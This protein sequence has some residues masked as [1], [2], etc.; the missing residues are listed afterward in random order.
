M[1]FSVLRPLSPILSSG[2]QFLHLK[3]AGFGFGVLRG[4]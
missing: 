1:G 4:W 3:S 2:F